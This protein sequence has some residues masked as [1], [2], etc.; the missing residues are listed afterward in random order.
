[1]G[2]VQVSTPQRYVGRL[3]A[4]L[5]DPELT[6]LLSDPEWATNPEVPDFVEAALYAWLAERSAVDAM[7]AAQ[8]HHWSLTAVRT[9]LEVVNDEHFGERNSFVEVEHPIAGRVVQ[10][11]APIRLSGARPL[12]RPAP[13]L[14]QHDEEIRAELEVVSSV[15]QP[16]HS[17]ET[18]LPLEGTRVLDLTTIWAGPYTT[19]LLADLGADVIRVEDAR[20]YNGTRGAVA[21]PPKS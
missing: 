11:S 3:L 9:P 5:G 13:L 8:L 16:K 10:P 4:T 12:R 2:W 19:M 7:N 15:Q 1:D 14:G 17:V 6:E 20:L 18:K 21:R